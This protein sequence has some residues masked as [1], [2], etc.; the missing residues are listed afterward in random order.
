MPKISKAEFELKLAVKDA[1]IH[2]LQA[3]LLSRAATNRKAGSG[4]LLF[5]F[6]YEL[7]GLQNATF[8]YLADVRIHGLAHYQIQK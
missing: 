1:E 7:A 3:A 5:C 2:K 8:D 4:I 6:L